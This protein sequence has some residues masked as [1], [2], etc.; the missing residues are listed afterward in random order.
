M[1]AVGERCFCAFVACHLL[2]CRGCCLKGNV[3]NINTFFFCRIKEE[4]FFFFHPLPLY[5]TL[6]TASWTFH[7]SRAAF[8][9]HRVYWNRKIK[10][11][12][13]ICSLL[14]SFLL[15]LSEKPSVIYLCHSLWSLKSV[16]Q[17]WAELALD[18]TEF[19]LMKR[20]LVPSPQERWCARGE[21]AVEEG[22]ET[23]ENA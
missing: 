6:N 17:I 3:W 1:L 15:F 16:R 22:L 13:E 7:S 10:C 4:Y 8:E 11:H 9:V 2:V 21:V 23:M 5:I 12:L 20:R 19:S 14:F 18:Q